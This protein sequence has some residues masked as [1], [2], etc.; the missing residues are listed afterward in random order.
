ME[1]EASWIKKI[2]ETHSSTLIEKTYSFIKKEW[3]KFIVD[4]DIAFLKYLSESYDKYSKV[5]SILY[6]TEPK[7]LR[8]FY[9]TPD[10][11]F[12]R[13]NDINGS[14]IDKLLDISNFLIIQGT[15]GLGKSTFMKYLFI[16]ELDRHDLIPILLELKDLNNLKDDYDICN[17]IFNQLCGLDVEFNYECLQYALKSGCFLFLLDGFDEI[18]S[19]KKNTFLMKINKFCDSYPTNYYIIST[20][21]CSDFVEFQRFSVLQLCEFSKDQAV[22]AIKKSY[23]YED[24]KANFAKELDDSLYEKHK[25]FA[26]NPL[27]LNMMLLTYE[28]YTNFPDQLHIFY[29]HAFDTLYTRHNATKVAYKREFKTNLSDDNFKKAFSNFCF[30][31]YLSG[32]T[33]FLYDDLISY[34]NKAKLNSL[35]YNCQDMV[36]DLVENVCVIQREGLYYRFVHT[37]FQ[38]YFAAIFLK[39]QT[40]KNLREL[41]IKFINKDPYRSINDTVFSMLYDMSTE[42]TEQNILLPLITKIEDEI[43]GNTYDIYFDEF[44][45]VFTFGLFESKDINLIL[46][47]CNDKSIITFIKKFAYRYKTVDTKEADN[48]LYQYLK[49]NAGYRPYDEI[50]YADIKS[51]VEIYNLFKSTWIGEL[52][53]TMSNLKNILQNKKANNDTDID[54][55]L[56]DYLCSIGE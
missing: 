42:R 12:G 46:V 44:K 27:L 54:N 33:E 51:N 11:R 39:E 14:D 17:L 15:G 52:I 21:P 5:K 55:L 26:S 31:T 20:R 8:G 6:R 10:L 16:E 34:L 41:S 3:N 7:L 45:P 37:P 43:G 38:E 19:S 24:I 22:T 49:T 35:N 32:E 28:N 29:A 47:K 25:S 36:Y 30:I 13:N 40:D 2:L 9:V 53:I 1:N 23:F 18:F 56:N 50:G 48:N 4:F